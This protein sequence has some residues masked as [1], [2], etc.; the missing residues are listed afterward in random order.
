MKNLLL[1]SCFC[2][3]LLASCSSTKNSASY[4]VQTLFDTTQVSKY[5]V[6]IKTDQAEISGIMLVK[7]IANEWR[8][9]LVNEFGVKAFDFVAPQGKCKLQN[10]ISFLNKWYIRKTV[11]A[12]F[13]FLFW[14]ATVGKQVKGK[15]FEQFSEEKFVLKNKKRNI[16]YSF[17]YIAE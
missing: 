13:A 11:E 14:E 10:A 15:K 4:S 5:R 12:D 3:L 6:L 2:L 9:S 16:E 8:G 1:I 17:N 7:Y